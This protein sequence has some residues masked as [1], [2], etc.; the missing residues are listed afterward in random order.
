[1]ATVRQSV[2]AA[3]LTH[4]ITVKAFTRSSSAE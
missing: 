2:P 3:G 1:M 4:A